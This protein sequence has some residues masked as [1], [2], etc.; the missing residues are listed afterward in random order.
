MTSTG[1]TIAALIIVALAAAGLLW[2]ALA[3]RGR[4]GCAGG[5]CGAVSA[6]AKA[7]LKKIHKG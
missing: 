4:S 2:R 1:Q 3:K 5:E 6:D 7:F